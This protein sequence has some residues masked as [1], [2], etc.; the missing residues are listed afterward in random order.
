MKID[1]AN[2]VLMLRAKLNLSQEDFAKMLN[3]SA[4]SINRWENGKCE[5]TKIAKVK[6]YQLLK[7]N[8]IDFNE[9]GE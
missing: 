4:V 3:V 1:Y 8:A 9:D 7:E 2:S 6:I 5:P